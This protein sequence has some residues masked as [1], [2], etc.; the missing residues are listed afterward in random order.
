[1]TLS[2]IPFHRRLGFKITATAAAAILV[3]VAI[4]AAVT[5]RAQHDEL[6]ARAQGS[7]A[8]LSETDEII[9]AEHLLAERAATPEVAK[10]LLGAVAEAEALA[11]FQGIQILPLGE[12]NIIGAAVGVSLELR[13]MNTIRI[14]ARYFDAYSLTAAAGVAF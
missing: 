14:E 8:I 4:V 10:Q 1:M 7:A 12:D 5:I 13:E 3:P 2:R 11:R 6:V 9:G